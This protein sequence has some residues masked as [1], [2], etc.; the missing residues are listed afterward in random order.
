VQSK[1]EKIVVTSSVKSRRTTFKKMDEKLDITY[2]KFERDSVTVNF[3]S[4]KAWNVNAPK[5]KREEL[6]S[7]MIGIQ[8]LSLSLPQ[9]SILKEHSGETTSKLIFYGTV[10][11]SFH[12]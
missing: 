3:P 1:I 5:C 12:M 8:S 10:N 7:K 4:L 2:L 11:L 9:K 6:T